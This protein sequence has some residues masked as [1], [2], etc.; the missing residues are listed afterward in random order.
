MKNIIQKVFIFLLLIGVIGCENM[1]QQEDL[2]LYL[3]PNEADQSL[4]LSTFVDSISYIPLETSDESMMVRVSE[5]IIKDKF[6]YAVDMEQKVVF[7]FDKKG[8]FVSKLARRGEGPD[9]YLWMQQVLV[10]DEESYIEIFDYRGANLRIVKY[11][12][13]TNQ[14]RGVRVIVLI[15]DAEKCDDPIAKQAAATHFLQGFAEM[16]SIYG[17][18]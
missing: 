8:K 16:D 5:I 7:I 14:D 6:I 9:E 4:H 10:D 11:A 13:Q 15:D 17:N 1:D 3:N 12:I 18:Y 2:V